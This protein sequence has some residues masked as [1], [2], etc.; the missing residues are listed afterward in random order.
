MK[1]VAQVRLM[2]QKDLKELVA[3]VAPV[4]QQDL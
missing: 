4:A 1:L 3:P 2:Q